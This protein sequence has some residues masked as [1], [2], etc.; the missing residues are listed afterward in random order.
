MFLWRNCVFI[1]SDLTRHFAVKAS[2]FWSIVCF[3]QWDFSH[4]SLKSSVSG[5]LVYPCECS[6]WLWKQFLIVVGFFFCL[7]A[8]FLLVFTFYWFM[9]IGDQPLFFWHLQADLRS[10]GFSKTGTQGIST[11]NLVNSEATSLELK[12]YNF[13]VLEL[14]TNENL[15]IQLSAWCLTLKGCQ[16]SGFL[17]LDLW[18]LSF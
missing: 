3:V 1:C 8:A 4:A 18:H 9:V 17:K 13:R 16:K 2:H 15:N 7:A 14:D 10:W 5:I 12:I 11:D 6:H